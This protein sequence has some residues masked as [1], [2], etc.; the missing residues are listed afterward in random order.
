LNGRQIRRKVGKR[1]GG[2]APLESLI[3]VYGENPGQ[4]TWAKLSQARE[5]GGEKRNVKREGVRKKKKTGKVFVRGCE[6]RKGLQVFAWGKRALW[7]KKFGKK[8]L[9]EGGK[10]KE[11]VPRQERFLDKRKT[12]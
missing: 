9:K 11:V 1:G 7:G 2:G 3:V 4:Q 8:K 10:V 5:L 12:S 6:I